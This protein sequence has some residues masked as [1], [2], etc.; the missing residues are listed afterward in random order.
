MELLT[1]L[2]NS[3]VQQ[4]AQYARDADVGHP[5]IYNQTLFH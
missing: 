3:Y 1:L 5:L 2:K 4:A